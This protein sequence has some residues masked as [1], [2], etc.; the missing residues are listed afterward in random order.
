ME[1]KTNPQQYLLKY[2]FIILVL[3]VIHMTL[4]F[5]TILFLMVIPEF[6]DKV[7]DLEYC[8]DV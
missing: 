6:K 3:A 7:R 8:E 2:S 5:A 1:Y 4:A